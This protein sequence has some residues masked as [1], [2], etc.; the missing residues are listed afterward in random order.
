MSNPKNWASVFACYPKAS[1]IYVA[2]NMPFLNEE[3][4]QGHAKAIGAEVETVERP[5]PKAAKAKPQKTKK[6]VIS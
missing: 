1:H 2:G 6:D 3:E 4:A 5:Q